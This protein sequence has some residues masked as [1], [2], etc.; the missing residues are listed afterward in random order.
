MFGRLMEPPVLTMQPYWQNQAR[1]N[2]Y[3]PPTN[4]QQYPVN[5]ARKPFRSQVELGFEL[6]PVT[7][8]QQ[9]S[10]PMAAPPVPIPMQDRTRPQ[11]MQVF[12]Q[13]SPRYT[14]QSTHPNG[15]PPQ[16]PRSSSASPTRKPLPSPAGVS[17]PPTVTQNSGF[18]PF[19]PNGA[20]SLDLSALSRFNQERMASGAISPGAIRNGNSVGPHPHSHP[21]SFAPPSQYPQYQQQN[22]IPPVSGHSPTFPF[23][24]PPTQ[25]QQPPSQ[26]S[27]PSTTTRRRASPPRFFENGSN[28]TS[29]NNSPEKINPQP[30]FSRN[31]PNPSPGI[32]STT[33]QIRSN[34]SA[35][36][37]Q[38]APPPA[39]SAFATTSSAA[40]RQHNPI[41]EPQTSPT[42][43]GSATAKSKFV[44]LW[45]RSTI[46][47]LNQ[48]NPSGSSTEVDRGR[49][50]AI[51]PAASS[52]PLPRP[53]PSSFSSQ[54]TVEEPEDSE[55]NT[56]FGSE[57]NVSEVSAVSTIASASSAASAHSRRSGASNGPGILDLRGSMPQPPGMDRAAA[58]TGTLYQGGGTGARNGISGGSGRSQF[59]ERQIP[60]PP[61]MDRAGAT[62]GDLR[63]KDSGEG[64]MTLRFAKMGL[65]TARSER[66]NWPSDL[67][68]LPKGPGSGFTGSSND[69]ITSSRPASSHSRP[70]G[71]S[72]H[73]HSRSQPQI[74]TQS[75][76]AAFNRSSS[77]HGDGSHG[78]PGRM[79]PSYDLDEPPPR[80]ASASFS[81]RSVS[82]TGSTTSTASSMTG[83]LER[84]RRNTQQHPVQPQPQHAYSAAFNGHGPG[85]GGYGGHTTAYAEVKIESP[86]PLGGKEKIAN[87]RKME[88]DSNRTKVVAGITPRISF[89]HEDDDYGRRDRGK[90]EVPRITFG[91]QDSDDSIS[92]GPIIRVSGAGESS[93]IPRITFGNDDDDDG[94]TSAGPMIRVSSAESKGTHKSPSQIVFEVP[95]IG[96][97][98]QFGSGPV[99]N[100]SEADEDNE[101]DSTPRRRG[102]SSSSSAAH[103]GGPRALPAARS[104]Q[105]GSGVRQMPGRGKAGLTCPACAK[106]IVGRI[107]GAMG[108]KWHPDCFRCTVCDELLEFQSSYEGVG[109]DGIKRPYC[110]LDYHET[111]APKCYHCKTAIVEERFI[112]LNDPALGRRTYHEPHF[113]CAE[114]GDPFLS[115]SSAAKHNR[116]RDFGKGAGGGELAF[117]GDGS[118][119]YDDDDD[120]VGFT[121]YKGHP[122][123]EACHVRLRLPKCKRCKKPIRDHMEAV[124]A[125]GGKWCWE[126]FRCTHCDKPFEDPS[127]FE[128]DKKP[129]CES[130]F[131]IIIRN[132]I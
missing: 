122:Y 19:H 25:H 47:S 76:F 67:P 71:P 54:Y 40:L 28:S 95:G 61:T 49:S 48:H 112:S 32:R 37:V 6:P 106:P 130:C 7:A 75:A 115:P 99:I 118:F 55:A 85:P 82:P 128:R 24:S 52:R 63:D 8:T 131:S 13:S 117:S 31:S 43:T 124:E 70:S 18:A 53:A 29:R 91:S 86:K 45:K 74:E 110:H 93:G 12:P 73:S 119:S 68:P 1:P 100:I 108:M 87:V 57:T 17:R 90:P 36:S 92:G 16:L 78:K 125:L 107:V 58:T 46:S 102:A 111:F 103:Q 101:L 69:G 89:D 5:S 109:E 21:N 96:V 2:G 15:V 94:S 80:P 114:C 79:M 44:P 77:S 121:V 4:N 9:R 59:V 105:M 126:C 62:T 65:D 35:T 116:E 66:E 33:S 23:T 72:R 113:F 120:N 98:G 26:P 51:P 42:H 97:A 123:C 64:S 27:F 88:N 50:I 11:S 30:L 127:F 38:S 104:S 34:P 84:F 3:Y 22:P 132:E 129:Y 14:P 20:Q 83:A 41:F 60:K 81:A 56:S 10:A 39:S